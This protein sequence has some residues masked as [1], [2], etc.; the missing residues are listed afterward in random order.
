VGH[1]REWEWRSTWENTNEYLK[2]RGDGCR[3][4][5]QRRRLRR[6]RKTQR[7]RQIG[8]KMR[9]NKYKKENSRV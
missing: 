3:D 4:K 6:D 7:P 9:T 5:F 8:V 2:S 1:I